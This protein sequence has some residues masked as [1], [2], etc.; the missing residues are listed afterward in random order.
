[1]EKVYLVEWIENCEYEVYSDFG[2]AMSKILEKYTKWAEGLEG[3]EILRDLND[4]VS[5]GYIEDFV[6]IC[7]K[8]VK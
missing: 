1:M 3:H 5:E 8:E 2:K 4:I 7:E 6:Y